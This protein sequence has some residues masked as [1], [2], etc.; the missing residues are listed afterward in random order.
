MEVP[1]SV[2]M[3]INYIV[4]KPTNNFIGEHCYQY[5]LHISAPFWTITEEYAY[6]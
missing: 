4:I 6:K 1:P 5:L 2:T 3:K